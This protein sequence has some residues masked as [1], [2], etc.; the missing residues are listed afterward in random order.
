[1]YKCKISVGSEKHM[2][3]IEI[4]SLARLYNFF[5]FNLMARKV[6]SNQN[7]NNSLITTTNGDNTLASN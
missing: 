3:I 4:H 7:V 5:V 1:M 6:I 2:Y